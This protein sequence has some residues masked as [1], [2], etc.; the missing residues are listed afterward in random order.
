MRRRWLGISGPSTVRRGFGLSG[1]GGRADYVRIRGQL[2]KVLRD[3]IGV[4]AG[5][6]PLS[7]S[8]RNTFG[9]RVL[10]TAGST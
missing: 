2:A 8:A 5:S 4:I 3:V 7:L 6:L 1:V 9:P 10:L